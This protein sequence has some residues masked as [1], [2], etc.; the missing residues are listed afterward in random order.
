LPQRIEAASKKVL[1]AAARYVLL[2]SSF[3]TGALGGRPD[4]PHRRPERD[5]SRKRRFALGLWGLS[6]RGADAWNIWV[7]ARPF[8]NGKRGV[9]IQAVAY[10]G[11]GFTKESDL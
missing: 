9:F 5:D 4:G 8:G 1:L 3:W 2:V 11:S 10:L 7:I 6:V